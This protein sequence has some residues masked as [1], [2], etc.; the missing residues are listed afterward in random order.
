MSAR[1]RRGERGLSQSVQ[2]ALIFP[3]L[4]LCTLGIIQSGMW[5]YG[6]HVASEAAHSAVDVGRSVDADV[7]SA[8]AAALRIA[9]VGGLSQTS[10]TVER[11]PTEVRAVVSAQV[12]VILDLGLGL[13]TESAA[14]PVE[15]VTAP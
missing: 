4:M 1:L 8:R 15:R 13:V 12:P 9:A 11:G 6:R 5:V 10:V 7:G 2:Y 3:A 14:A